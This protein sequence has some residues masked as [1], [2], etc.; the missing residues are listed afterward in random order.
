MLLSG[1]GKRCAGSYPIFPAPSMGIVNAV[2][3]SGSP[4]LIKWFF[5]DFQLYW[6]KMD[7]RED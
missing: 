5:I 4:E 2:E 3:A 1:C 7:M 6:D